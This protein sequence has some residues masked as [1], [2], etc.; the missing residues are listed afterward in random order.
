MRL[1]LMKRF[2][3]LLVVA[4]LAAAHVHKPANAAGDALYQ[5]AS[6]VEA[7]LGIVPAQITKDHKPTGPEG[8]MHGSVPEGANQY[9]LV[10]AIFDAMSGE[11]I[12]DAIVTGQVSARGKTGGKQ[13][14]DLMSIEG[15]QT[16][17][18]Y[19]TFA[20]PGPYTIVLTISRQG[21]AKVITLSFP[22]EHRPR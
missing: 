8:P 16:Y 15:T 19:F 4:L 17:G 5:K 22:Y 14:L 1:R 3:P 21:A 10:A 20:G 11:R 7:Y 13:R 9:H 18:G 2:L 6:G 12:T